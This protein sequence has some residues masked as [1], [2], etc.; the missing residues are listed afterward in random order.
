[1]SVAQVKKRFGEIESY[2][3]RDKEAVRRLK[4][5]KDDVNVLRTSLAAAEKKA[6]EAEVAKE[7]ARKRADDAELQFV[8]LKAETDRLNQKNNTSERERDA[9]V[10]ELNEIKNKERVPFATGSL[11]DDLSPQR[12]HRWAYKT[13]KEQGGTLIKPGKCTTRHP[14]CFFLEDVLTGFDEFGFATLGRTIVLQLL[15][16]TAITISWTDEADGVDPERIIKAVWKQKDSDKA[17]KT[18]MQLFL[19]QFDSRSSDEILA[20]RT[21][22]RAKVPEC[23]QTAVDILFGENLRS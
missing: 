3:G 13:L 10:N 8:E 14:I 15:L 18:M 7:L 4:L 2:L 19:H 9:V 20:Y 11:V 6:E 5:L 16:R 22:G 23:T 17:K 1:M 21:S 12:I